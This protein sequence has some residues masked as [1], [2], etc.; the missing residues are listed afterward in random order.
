[1][2]RSPLDICWLLLLLRQAFICW[3]SWG[4]CVILISDLL[5]AQFPWHG[6]SAPLITLSNTMFQA[7]L[8][9]VMSTFSKTEVLGLQ[10]APSCSLFCPT[11]S[12]NFSFPLLLRYSCVS[13]LICCIIR[14]PTNEWGASLLNWFSQNFIIWL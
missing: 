13:H 2:F 11:F 10:T 12:L 7:L 1:M 9:S 6:R 8:L 3:L 4:A 14:S 5:S